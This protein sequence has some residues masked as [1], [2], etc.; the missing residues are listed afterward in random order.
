MSG[1]GLL[2]RD[3]I[4]ALGGA[5]APPVLWALGARAQQ[6]TMPVIGFPGSASLEKW[7]GGVL[8]AYKRGLAEA[9]YVEDRN[10]AIEY[11]W[12]EEQY[13]RLPALA[14]ELAHQR[15]AVIVAPGSMAATVATETGPGRKESCATTR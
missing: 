1:A 3:F 7:G 14:A 10:V 13:D 15:V 12:A 8:I 6:R 4:T 5:A 2:R 9:G 11:R